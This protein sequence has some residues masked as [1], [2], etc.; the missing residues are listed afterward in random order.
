MAASLSY[1]SSLHYILLL[2]EDSTFKCNDFLSHFVN[3]D[4]CKLDIALSEFKLRKS[5]NKKVG[6]FYDNNSILHR[7]ELARIVKRNISLT[8]CKL[9]FKLT[10]RLLF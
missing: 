2:P 3:E 6:T 7:S 4:I 8:K 1:S 10:G 9:G 5:F